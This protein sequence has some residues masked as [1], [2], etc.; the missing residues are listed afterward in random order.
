MTVKPKADLASFFVCLVAVPTFYVLPLLLIPKLSAVL[1]PHALALSWMSLDRIPGATLLFQTVMTTLSYVPAVILAPLFV[2]MDN[3]DPRSMFEAG[4]A[5]PLL[6]RLYAAH[7]NNIDTFPSLLA[8]VFVASSFQLD[9]KVFADLCV[10][11]VLSRVLY[12]LVYYLNLDMA[13]SLSYTFGICSVLLMITFSLFESFQP[14]LEQVSNLI[15]W[16]ASLLN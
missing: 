9:A 11:F 5:P 15:P 8:G 16:P 3:R 14:K 13:R 10:I 4:V 12:H 6:R 7:R 2:K 1:R